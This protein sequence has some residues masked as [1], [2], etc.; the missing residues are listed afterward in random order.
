MC[1]Y[2]CTT[3]GITSFYPLNIKILRHILEHIISPYLKYICV[4][5][6]NFSVLL[7]IFFR[8]IVEITVFY[9]YIM[10]KRL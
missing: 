9:A 2:P 8:L 6:S 10:Y 4:Y 5:Y 1:P 7:A 3:T